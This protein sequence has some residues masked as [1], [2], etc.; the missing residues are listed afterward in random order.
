M[1]VGTSSPTA[2]VHITAPSSGSTLKVGRLS[3]QP[4]IEG[5]DSWMMIE[6]SGANPL[7]LNYYGSN[8]VVLVNGFAEG[9]DCS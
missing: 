1:G 6:Q 8:D 7:A 5:T 9:V 3:G 2:K 4:S